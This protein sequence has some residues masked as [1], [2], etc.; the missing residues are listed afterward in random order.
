M[1]MQAFCKTAKR[2]ARKEKYSKSIW[3]EAVAPISRRHTQKYVCS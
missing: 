1:L 3:F 2:K